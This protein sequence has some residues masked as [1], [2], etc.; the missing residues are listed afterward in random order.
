MGIAMPISQRT[1]TL[2]NSLASAEYLFKQLL[3]VL[4]W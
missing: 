3:G 4:A 2:N 1:Q